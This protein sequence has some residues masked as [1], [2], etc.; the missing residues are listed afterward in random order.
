MPVPL[1]KICGIS[2][3][4]TLEATIAARA[5][6]VGLMFYAPSPR[7]VSLETA[8]AL[9]A[10]GGSRIGRVGVFVDPDDALLRDAIA[11]GRLDAVQLH[12]VSPARR[13][14]VRAQTGL[15]VW[16]VREVAGPSDLATP[17]DSSTFD[18]L[19]YD[20]KTPKSALPGGMGLSFDWAMLANARHP[21]AWGLAG[22][23][24]AA[25]AAVAVRITGAPLLDV[26]SGVESAPGVKDVD[27]I[28]AF[29][30][31]ARS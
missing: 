16:A 7:F 26:S 13:A 14:E 22:G 31:A 12:R 25:N 20:A 23:L 27:R 28:A 2:T 10:H 1:I 24:S 9:A 17:D 8:A 11:A 5:E 18:R 15:P 3:A 19:I 30:K 4:E 21:A 29:C 6:Y